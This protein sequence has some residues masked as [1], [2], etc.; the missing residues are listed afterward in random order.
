M[1]Q[2][3]NILLI[4]GSAEAHE[5]ATAMA[6]AGVSARAVLRR[7]ERSFGPLAVPSEIWSPRDVD[8]VEAYLRVHKFTAV[9]DA[10]HGF[11]A[12]ISQIAFGAA[13]QLNLPY[14]RIVR[15]M[16]DITA[17][18]ERAASVAEAALMIRP[19]ARVFAATGRGTLDQ[20]HPFSGARLY[21]RQT[22]A[23]ARSALPPFAEAVFG[24]PPFTRAAEAELFRRLQID[25]LVLRNVGGAPSRPKLDAALDLGLR[26]IVIDRPSP[27]AGAQALHGA[28]AGLRW[29][30]TL[31]R[32]GVGL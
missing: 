10:G 11:D 27:P 32:K 7:A 5:I 24:Q 17:P 31:P 2:S 12:D 6:A 22:N 20:Y 1:N 21:L 25:T 29:I 13:A 28:E 4:A 9:L 16:W 3:P 8:E 18:A 23:E 30:E 14:V 19:E 26:V 15:P